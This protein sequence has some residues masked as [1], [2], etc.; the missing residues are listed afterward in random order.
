MLASLLS[1]LLMLQCEA[2]I[3]HHC[4]DGTTVRALRELV[5]ELLISRN[6]KERQLATLVVGN[7]FVTYF[8]F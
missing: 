1:W 4:P 6:P 8:L 2:C 7:E 3:S 5:S